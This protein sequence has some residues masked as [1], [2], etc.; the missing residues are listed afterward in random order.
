MFNMVECG[1]YILKDAFF[2]TMNDP[3]LKNNKEGSRPFYY[4]VKGEKD[5]KDIYWMIP[6]SSRIE[7]YQKIIDNK[8]ASGKP[9]DGIYI[10]KLPSGTDSVFLIQDIFPVTDMYI[11]RSYTLGGNPLVLPYEEEIAIINR[12]AR[13]VLSLIKR[14]IQLTPTSPNVLAIYEKL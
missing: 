11:D 14:G 6:L 13:K 3:Y 5:G 8:V 9:C 7:K 12:K 4:C 10:T 2:D 1:F